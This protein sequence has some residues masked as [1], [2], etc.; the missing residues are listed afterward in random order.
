MSG[1]RRLAKRILLLAV[2]VVA[3]VACNSADR[4][5][6]VKDGAKGATTTVVVTFLPTPGV[7]VSNVVDLDPPGPSLGDRL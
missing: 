5:G 6:T 2:P 3:L 7:P 1:K 4:A